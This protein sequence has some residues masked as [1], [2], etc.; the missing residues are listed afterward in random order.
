MPP[1]HARSDGV[2]APVKR[3]LLVVRQPGNTRVLDQA[4]REIGMAATTAS[5]QDEMAQA[6]AAIDEPNIALVDASG[7]GPG[8]WPLCEQLHESG[9]PFVV[10]SASRDRE[11]GDQSLA[12]G[13]ARVVE[14]PVAKEALLQLLRSLSQ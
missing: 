10:M 4:V 14:K 3:V 1:S 9:V 6:L 5:S 12:Y 7:F 8:L 2:T 11:A 13:A